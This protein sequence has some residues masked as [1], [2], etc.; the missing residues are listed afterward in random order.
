MNTAPIHLDDRRG[1]GLL[2]WVELARGRFD[3]TLP[4]E[5][6]AKRPGAGLAPRAH[7]AWLL[8]T[9]RANCFA[10]FVQVNV[11]AGT[12]FQWTTDQERVWGDRIVVN[13][14]LG[15]ADL[16]GLER[17][18]GRAALDEF[19]E[20][21]LWAQARL[22]QAGVANGGLQ[23]F[24]SGYRQRGLEWCSLW[25]A[26]FSEVQVKQWNDEL[27]AWRKHAWFERWM[28]VNLHGLGRMRLGP[29]CWF[30]TNGL[31]GERR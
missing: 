7:Q 14:R 10:P 25:G 11:H 17:E 1:G 20:F 27:L 19:H 31:R 22:E 23:W 26:D 4:V 2:G 16:F 5:L 6:F 12:A 28:A 13:G 3:L 15:A 24:R 8:E 9:L 21:L 30:S 18:R 29:H